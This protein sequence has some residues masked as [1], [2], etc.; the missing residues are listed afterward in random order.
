MR[1][2]FKTI[3]SILVMTFTLSISLI[4]FF[5]CV[6]EDDKPG[7]NSGGTNNKNTAHCSPG[8]CWVRMVNKCCPNNYPIYYSGNCYR[9][10]SDACKNCS[11]FQCV[12]FY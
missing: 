4:G 1:I 5:S 9:K 10:L 12:T 2:K 8:Y 6:E 7:G 3:A 11:G